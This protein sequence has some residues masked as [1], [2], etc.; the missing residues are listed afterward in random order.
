LIGLTRKNLKIIFIALLIFEGIASLV[1]SGRELRYPD[2][3]QYYRLAARLTEGAGYVNDQGKP[4]AQWPPGYPFFLSLVFRV[5]GDPIA[6][7]IAN[8]LLL[9]L[10]VLLLPKF[11]MTKA[12]WDGILTNGQ[13][14][15]YPL[16]FYCA[17]TLYP[18]ILGSFILI[19][20]LFLITNHPPSAKR[21]FAA[22]IIFGS[23]VLVIPYFFSLLPIV[24]I[25]LYKQEKGPIF[26]R[27]RG[28]SVLLVGILLTLAP[29]TLRNWVRF[30]AV[31]PV[32]TNS[33]INLLRGNYRAVGPNDGV[34]ADVERFLRVDS[35]R[36]ETER[37][38]LYKR[39]ALRWIRENKGPA[40]RLYVE[41]V[42]NYFQFRN[43]LRVASEDTFVRRTFLFITYYP[44]LILSL[45]RLF[46]RR[47]FPMDQTETLFYWLYFGNAFISAVFF[48]RIRFRVP[49]DF[50]LI[51][52]VSTFLGRVLSD[53]MKKRVISRAVSPVNAGGTPS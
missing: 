48:T 17:C 30:R 13:I 21:L 23:G 49:F 3:R 22:G 31:V 27:L 12:A 41:K 34:T 19:L 7:K 2:E 6:M 37:D 50:L 4:T 53:H 28:V 38:A 52:M 29:W 8:L 5:S 45:V 24:F 25:W 43:Q 39:E 42:L 40:V 16:F 44:L 14:C 10:I 1:L 36:T 20:F 9:A 35:L 32:S 33:G 18:Q 11:D 46:F 51:A 26:H 15:L 47:R